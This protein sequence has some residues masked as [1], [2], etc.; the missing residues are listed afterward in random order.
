MFGVKNY[1]NKPPPL[2]HMTYKKTLFLLLFVGLIFTSYAQRNLDSLLEKEDYEGIEEHL[3]SLA[4]GGV[5]SESILAIQSVFIAADDAKRGR[6]MAGIDQELLI[7][8][9][10]FA[11]LRK[12]GL[13]NFEQG[14]VGMES[15]DWIREEFKRKEDWNS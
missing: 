2:Y 5:A 11:Q 6:I 3:N 13:E 10:D 15:L 7:S 14:Q 12:K 9:F 4:H 1:F 8:F